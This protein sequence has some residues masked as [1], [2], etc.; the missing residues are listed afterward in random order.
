MVSRSPG[1]RAL[2]TDV[3]FFIGVALVIVSIAGVWLLVAASR[4]TVPVLQASRTIVRGESLT[5][6]DFRVAEVGLGTLADDYLAPQDLVDGMIADR[7][8]RSGELMPSSAAAGESTATTTSL[9]VQSAG[10]LPDDITAGTRVEVWQSP[11]TEDGRGYEKPRVLVADAVVADVRD[12]EGMLENAHTDVEI[13]IDRADVSDMLT[14][15]TGGSAI[16]L[17]AAGRAE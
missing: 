4:H 14:A 16:S 3:R 11:A 9:V 13:V 10:P 1:S 15:T 6:A 2:F 8:V 5:S 12:T 17:I 7:T